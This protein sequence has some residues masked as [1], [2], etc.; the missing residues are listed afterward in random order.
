MKVTLG[1]E[2]LNKFDLKGE[3]ISVKLKVSIEKAP[4]K[5]YVLNLKT[6]KIVRARYKKG[7]LSFKT[8]AVGKFVIVR[9]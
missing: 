7:S 4:E 6:G 5:I 3:K 1:K 2:N 9:K 8:D